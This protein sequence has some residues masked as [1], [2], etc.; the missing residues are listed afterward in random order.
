MNTQQYLCA[1]D[2]ISA[3]RKGTDQ[4]CSSFIRSTRISPCAITCLTLVVS[5]VSIL[6]FIF[7]YFSRKART[8]SACPVSEIVPFCLRFT[9]PFTA[10][11]SGTPLSDHTIHSFSVPSCF[12]RVYGLVLSFCPASRCA[13]PPFIDGIGNNRL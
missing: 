6:G 3:S 13:D 12:S 7:E 8:A 10:S 4:R 2:S 5:L 1:R 9:T 11:S